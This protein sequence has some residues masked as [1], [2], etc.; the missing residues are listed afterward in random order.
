MNDPSYRVRY[1]ARQAVNNINGDEL[2]IRHF[3]IQ[4]AQKDKT[5]IVSTDSKVDQDGFSALFNNRGFNVETASTTEETIAKA[6]RF[7]ADLIITDNQKKK[8]NEADNLSGLNMTRDICRNLNLSETII[9]IL[10][11]DYIEPIFLWLGGDYYMS[12]QNVSLGQVETVVEE[13]LLQ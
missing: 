5:I 12:K 4:A 8:V 10:T 11:D 1:H 13:Y 3:P 6:F 2:N 9:V 7:K